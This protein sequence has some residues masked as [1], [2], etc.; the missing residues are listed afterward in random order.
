ME[1]PRRIVRI[2]RPVHG[3]G[4]SRTREGGSRGS[5][6][7]PMPRAE[8]PAYGDRVS[9]VLTA[10]AR[11]LRVGSIDPVVSAETDERPVPE[12]AAPR[13]RRLVAG[14]VRGGLTLVGLLL[15]VQVARGLGWYPSNLGDYLLVIVVTALAV[16]IG[17]AAPLPVLLGIAILVAFPGWGFSQPLLRMLPL[18]LAA[19]LSTSAGLRLAIVVPVTV[20]SAALGLMPFVWDPSTWGDDGW[21]SSR[22]LL[23]AFLL[24]DPSTRTLAFVIVIAGVLLGRASWRQQLAAIKLR[25]RNEEL[26]RLRELDRARIVA[27]ERTTIARDIHDVVA[28]HVAAMV[29]R[30]QAAVRVADQD[31]DELRETVAWVA[32]SGQEALTAMRDVVRVLRGSAVQDAA[33]ALD[34]RGSIAAAV[35]RVRDAGLEV[36]ADLRPLPPLSVL[37]ELAL[38]RVC[39]EALTNVLLHSAAVVAAVDLGPEADE[40]VLRVVDQVDPAPA[41]PP[42]TEPVLRGGG[43]GLPG[44]RERAA[45]VGAVLRAGPVSGGWLVELRVPV[46]PPG[47]PE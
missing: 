43:S 34:L 47:A 6:E 23:D 45:A 14:L 15:A 11:V 25:E 29:I 36:T 32:T 21:S 41:R 33:S 28:H 39:Q 17:R 18:L 22:T 4:V 27:E 19:F 35:E 30:S 42:R 5:A 2:R 31:P 20:L 9:R 1:R 46:V 16:A 7:R 13:S 38:L 12:P 8:G 24:N 3:G 26:E 40:V 10:S 44:M 37:Q